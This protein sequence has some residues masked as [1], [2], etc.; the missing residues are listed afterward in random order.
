MME[1]NDSIKSVCKEIADNFGPEKVILYNL[2]RSLTG[3]IRSFK[4]CVIVDTEN[5]LETERHIYL[6]VDSDIPFDVLVY[7]PAEWD[8]LLQEKNSFAYRIINEGTYMHG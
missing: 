5:R 8:R 4:I 1:L 7:T 3:E 6:D 2:K